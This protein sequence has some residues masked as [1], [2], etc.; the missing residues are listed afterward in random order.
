MPSDLAEIRMIFLRPEHPDIANPLA[1]MRATLQ[2]GIVL[3][4]ASLATVVQV[5]RGASGNID[6]MTYCLPGTC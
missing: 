3:T 5:S 2:M 6:E 4:T 1:D